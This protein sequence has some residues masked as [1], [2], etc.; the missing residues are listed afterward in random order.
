MVMVIFFMLSA[1]VNVRLLAAGLF[2]SETN[3]GKKKLK[4]SRLM[5]ETFVDPRV[6]KEAPFK[7]STRIVQKK[8]KKYDTITFLVHRNPTHWL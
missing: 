7:Q 4:K 6:E 8:K 2:S 5:I 3:E 1:G